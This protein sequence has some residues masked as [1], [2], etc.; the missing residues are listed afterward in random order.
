MKLNPVQQHRRG[1]DTQDLLERSAEV[2]VQGKRNMLL[3]L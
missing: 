3:Y 1:C 2:G